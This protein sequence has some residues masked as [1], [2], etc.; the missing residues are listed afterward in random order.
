MNKQLI[1]LWLRTW[2]ACL[3]LLGVPALDQSCP[4]L[5]DDVLDASSSQPLVDLLAGDA[6]QFGYLAGGEFSGW[7]GLLDAPCLKPFNLHNGIRIVCQPK[8]RLDTNPAAILILKSDPN[9]L[10][11]AIVLPFRFDSH[12]VAS[13]NH[14]F[15]T[16]TFAALLD[17]S[18]ITRPSAVST[19][20]G[21]HAHIVPIRLAVST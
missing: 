20:S 17:T 1:T 10:V 9:E 14:L 18:T 11:V 21:C 7:H 5:Q 16:R 6:E 8:L 2:P 12:S 3:G 4:V 19:V 13:F 15:H